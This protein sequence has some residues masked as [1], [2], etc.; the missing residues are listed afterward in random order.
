MVTFLYFNTVKMS[1]WTD[2]G[3]GEDIGKNRK[4][5]WQ[6]TCLPAPSEAVLFFLVGSPG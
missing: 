5:L 6:S 1:E 2:L 3:R 4:L